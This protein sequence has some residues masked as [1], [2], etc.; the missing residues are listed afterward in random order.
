MQGVTPFKRSPP[1]FFHKNT[2]NGGY[3]KKLQHNCYVQAWRASPLPKIT[4]KES[5]WPPQPI[6]REG[7]LTCLLHFS[8]RVKSIMVFVVSQMLRQDL[9]AF[10]GLII[11]DPHHFAATFHPRGLLNTS[12]SRPTPTIFH[13]QKPWR[14]F[15][16]PP[17]HTTPINIPYPETLE[18]FPNTSI[19]HSTPI[20]IPY[21]EGSL[22]LW[23]SSISAVVYVLH[24]EKPS[25]G[26]T[27]YVAP[28]PVIPTQ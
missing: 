19:F 13:I 7:L 3:S 2:R 15:K 11:S 22:K 1:C 6:G 5:F 18:D 12:I 14:T 10:R 23:A 4:L 20:N 28:G 17:F 9:N 21:P 8:L 24:Q 25:W 26:I 27:A 16:S